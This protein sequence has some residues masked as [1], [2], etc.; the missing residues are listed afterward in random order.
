MSYSEDN[1]IVRYVAL[2]HAI[3]Q[4]QTCMPSLVSSTTV[5]PYA[6]VLYTHPT[7]IRSLALFLRN[8][9]SLQAA[10]L[11]DIIVAD[12]CVATGRF[13]V[14]YLLLSIR[15]NARLLISFSVSE[16]GS[17]PSLTTPF[18]NNQRV[19]ASAG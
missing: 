2:N 11:T 3:D 8:S 17:I 7:A 5:T 4:V 13:T 9:T 15:L 19:F 1:K 14:K 16:T 18:F 12:R 10:T 6:C